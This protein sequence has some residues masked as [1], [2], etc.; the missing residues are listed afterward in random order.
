MKDQHESRSDSVGEYLT[1]GDGDFT[2]SFDLCRFLQAEAAL[3]MINVNIN[4]N[5]NVNVNSGPK[6]TDHQSQSTSTSTRIRVVCSGIDPLCEL[7][8]KYKD[9]NFIKNK[10]EGMNG[11][12]PPITIAR[13]GA[14]KSMAGDSMNASSSSNEGDQDEIKTKAPK[15]PRTSET[16]TG[17]LR[18][19]MNVSMHHSVNA[20]VPWTKDPSHTFQEQE[21][22]LPL[23]LVLPLTPSPSPPLPL[24][25]CK[26][27]RVIFNHPHI[28]NEDAQL[29]SRFLSHFFHSVH[30]HWLA[31]NG[32]VH[33]ALVKGQCERWKC[34][35][36]AEKHGFVLVHR[37]TFKPPPSPGQYIK[38]RL[39]EMDMDMNVIAMERQEQG[40]RQRHIPNIYQSKQ[41]FK[42]RFKH[43]RHQSGRSFASRAKDGSETLSFGRKIEMDQINIAIEGHLPWQ[44]L[45]W[46]EDENVFHCPH[47][48]CD[49]SFGDER[50]RKN[51]V[52]CVH[53]N[54]G[55]N[56]NES[57]SDVGSERSTGPIVCEIC[58]HDRIFSNKEALLA[59][60]KAK[61]T[62]QFTDIKPD[63]A[64]AT[65]TASTV[66]ATSEN[67][68]LEG[69]GVAE[70][71][72][73]CISKADKDES[74][75]EDEIIGTC[76]ICGLEYK[77]H[78]MKLQHYNQFIPEFSTDEKVQKSVR[79]LLSY[80]CF[81][82]NKGFR[83]QRAQKQHE[84]FCSV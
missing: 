78:A 38:S 36:A 33:L 16:N 51:H 84:N 48:H 31:P 35:D 12:V 34:I 32:T 30:T 73:D 67:E 2:Y 13:N 44:N 17:A 70:K 18:V 47:P 66:S 39:E 8:K 20:I 46:K 25:P 80:P 53:D 81:K 43:R 7:E 37:D 69:K 26:Y 11:L 15:R 56:E 45:G 9:S 77:N 60:Q 65:R 23:S 27:K 82:C 22:A 50:A 5:V 76:N 55:K 1:L 29:H 41:A 75:R 79:D 74:A 19:C 14:P 72:M 58:G 21:R 40:Q 10:I 49:K 63:W 83:D 52:K 54:V 71:S 42:R 64:S 28:G 68:S 24:T 3:E 61:H 57:E 4:V 59:H 6:E 62:G